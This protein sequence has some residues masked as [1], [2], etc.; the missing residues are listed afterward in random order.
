MAELVRQ[1]TRL[2]DISSKYRACPATSP[3]G[4][5]QL[6]SQLVRAAPQPDRALFFGLLGPAPSHETSRQRRQAHLQL[7]ATH[8]VLSLVSPPVK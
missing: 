7:P 8:L 4:Q 5:A 6:A 1:V 3:E 2:G